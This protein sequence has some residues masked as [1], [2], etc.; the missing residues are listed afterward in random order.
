MASAQL[1]RPE[2]Q[3]KTEMAS[4]NPIQTF[5]VQGS[6]NAVEV[7]FFLQGPRERVEQFLRAYHASHEPAHLSNL[8]RD[9]QDIFVRFK[10]GNR[11][12]ADP[13]EVLGEVC[14]QLGINPRNLGSW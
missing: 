4:S 7:Q 11:E 2:E 5:F 10:V 13:R 8:L 9:Y 14:R 1:R 12:Y 6:Q 3:A